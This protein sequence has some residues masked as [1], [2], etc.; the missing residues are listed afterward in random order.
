MFYII[1]RIKRLIYRFDFFNNIRIHDIIFIIHFEFVIDF[2]KKL[3]KRR[4]S[5]LSIIIIDEKNK[6]QMKKFVRKRR[7]KRKRD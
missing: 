6:Y 4:R 5:S 3:Y 1:K 2:K 7:I